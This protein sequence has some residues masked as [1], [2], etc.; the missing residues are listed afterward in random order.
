MRKEW[1][2]RKFRGFMKKKKRCN[3]RRERIKKS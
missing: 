1:E 3:R 2:Y